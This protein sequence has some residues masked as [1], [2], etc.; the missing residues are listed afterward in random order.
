MKNE[1]LEMSVYE[2]LEQV[3]DRESFLSFIKDLGLGI[4]QII[5]MSSIIHLPRTELSLRSSNIRF[6]V[7]VKEIIKDYTVNLIWLLYSPFC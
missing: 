3:K 2:S 7:K 5:K 4:Q 1:V 6:A